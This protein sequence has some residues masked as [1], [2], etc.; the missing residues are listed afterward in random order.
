[1]YKLKTQLAYTYLKHSESA[2]TLDGKELMLLFINE[3]KDEED[4]YSFEATLM[5]QGFKSIFG[6]SPDSVGFSS[7]GGKQ[8]SF[9]TT[10][11]NGK[12]FLYF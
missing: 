1:M 3:V 6:T 4:G 10:F 8:N 2:K 7:V 9:K 5:E 12:T 11:Q